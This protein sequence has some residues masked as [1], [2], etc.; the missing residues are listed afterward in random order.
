MYVCTRCLWS[1]QIDW[2][3]AATSAF[4]TDHP[5]PSLE[6]S[7]WVT[8]VHVVLGWPMGW[9]PVVELFSDS[10]CSH[11]LEVTKP[12]Q[13]AF[14]YDN[15][16]V[17]I[18]KHL[19]LCLPG[20]LFDHVVIIID[21]LRTPRKLV[22]WRDWSHRSAITSLCTPRNTMKSLGLSYLTLSQLF[23]IYSSQQ[24]AKSNTTW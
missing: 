2:F 13:S 8:F 22:P 21:S 9:W 10:I 23:G 18:T 14:S 15:I 16:V 20:C 5:V 19:L 24:A 17:K 4:S 11:S 12:L 6:R 3:W 1:F 7:F